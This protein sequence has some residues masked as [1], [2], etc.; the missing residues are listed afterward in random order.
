[1]V[2]GRGGGGFVGVLGRKCEIQQSSAEGAGGQLV[3][4]A[5]RIFIVGA[6]NAVT[7]KAKHSGAL[8]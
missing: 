6:S 5:V 4:G 1:M 8:C 7:I 3:V 2:E